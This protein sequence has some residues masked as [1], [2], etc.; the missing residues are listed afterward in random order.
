M[1]VKYIRVSTIEQNT[2]RQEDFKGLTY[3]DKCSGSIAFKD[4]KEA[5]KLLANNDVTEILVHSIDRL[6]RN[7]IDIMNTIQDFTDRG[8]NV[9]SQKEGLQTILDG[10]TA[11]EF[12]EGDKSIPIVMKSDTSQQQTLESIET[13]NVFSQ[14]TGKTVPF[15]QVASITP[16]W[17]YAKITRLDI[18]R[19]ITVSSE[20]REGG[21]ASLITA[22]ITPWLVEQSK[23]WNPGYSYSFGGDAENTAENMGAVIKYLPLCGFIIMMLLIIQFNSFRK[24]IMV[25]CTIPL[26]II[27][28]VVGLLSFQEPFG[29][30]P[31]LGVIALAGIIIN[32][33]IVLIDR[34]EIEQN[35][36]E[37]KEEDSVITACL[38]RF[39]PIL[40]ATFT[41]VLGLIPLY[42]TGGEMW[43][44]MAIS[45]MVGLLFG[46]IITLFFIPAFYS[47]LYKIDYS[48]YVFDETLLD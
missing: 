13:L 34:M 32:N 11:G 41:T 8:I 4:R 38:Q 3:K 6:G 22:Q 40:L 46:T 42:L 31:F 14:N 2:D 21:N 33:A 24:M 45:I 1:R 9:V 10:F 20:L 36:L 7:T 5:S 28:V 16:V 18:N 44:G 25:Y 35:V 26:A 12:R 15:S 19:T 39:R 27:G 17:Q 37:R 29:F 23:T 43:E 48:E 47:V 30:M